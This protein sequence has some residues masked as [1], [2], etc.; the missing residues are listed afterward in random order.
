MKLLFLMYLEDDDAMVERRLQELDVTVYSRIGL[1]GQ[2]GGGGGWYGEA[3]P[4]R[5]R[6]AFAVLPDDQ[7][8]RLLANVRSWTGAADPAHPVRAF[9]VRVEDAAASS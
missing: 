9:I 6:M 3:V 7:A 5:S 2:G 4:Y 8:D 1:E